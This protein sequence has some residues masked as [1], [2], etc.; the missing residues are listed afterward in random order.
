MYA[1]SVICSNAFFVFFIQYGRS[2]WVWQLAQM[3]L[4]FM[5]FDTLY[6]IVLMFFFF[7]VI[8]NNVVDIY[9]YIQF[10]NKKT[11]WYWLWQQF[12]LTRP[13]IGKAN[14]CQFHDLYQLHEAGNRK[15]PSTQRN[16]C[17]LILE[18]QSVLR[19]PLNNKSC[20]AKYFWLT[21]M[22]AP[23]LLK[24]NASNA[25]SPSKHSIIINL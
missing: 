16:L 2:Q 3:M 8:A 22:P 5:N 23:N 7:F 9:V 19:S 12:S 1:Q 20:V 11:I 14:R 10:Q 25:K 17:V 4:I 13:S 6:W 24:Y 21:L 18:L 15:W